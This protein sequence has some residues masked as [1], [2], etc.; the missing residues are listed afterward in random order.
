[1]PAACCPWPFCAGIG[2]A[3]A[4]GHNSTAPAVTSDGSSV[5]ART[6]NSCSV[7]YTVA[8]YHGMQMGWGQ[9]LSEEYADMV[10][11]ACMARSQG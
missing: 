1:M 9:G 11:E 3:A 8:Y 7:D 4:A 5:Q 10:Y 6:V 2:S